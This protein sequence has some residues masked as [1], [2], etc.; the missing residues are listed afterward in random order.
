MPTYYSR[1]TSIQ[2][3]VADLQDTTIINP[4]G[5]SPSAMDDEVAS[6]AAKFAKASINGTLDET[7]ILTED[8]NQTHMRC[9]GEFSEMPFFMVRAGMSFFNSE[10]EGRRSRRP[11]RVPPSTVNPV[12]RPRPIQPSMTSPSPRAV[13]QALF[14]S[15]FLSKASFLPTYVNRLNKTIFHDVKI[16]VF[17]N[18][19][20]CAS[21]YVSGRYHGDEY[22]MT[23]QIVRFSG[24][25]VHRLLEKPWIL[26]PFGHPADGRLRPERQNIGSS[27]DAEQRWASVSK[28]LFMEANKLEKGRNGELSKL[29]DYLSA[30]AALEMPTEVEAMQTVGDPKIGIIDVVVT[31]GMGRKDDSNGLRLMQ[32][33]PI[34]LGMPKVESAPTVL[35][36]VKDR[37]VFERRSVHQEVFPPIQ[38]MASQ[39]VNITR[40]LTIA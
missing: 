30:L 39:D 26:I 10:T 19:E 32:P 18:G 37:S 22:E 15:V 16:D 12:S 20:L 24:R 25:R 23:E 17:F 13:P 11:A 7:S 36:N 35:D 33:T 4:E 27:G 3:A 2:L 21:A 1:N 38:H 40:E 8:A 29:G 28:A 31:A 34:R 14:L 6:C 9:L 5:R